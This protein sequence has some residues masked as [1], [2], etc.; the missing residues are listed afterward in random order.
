MPA[1][2]DTVRIT[3]GGKVGTTD[4]WSTTQAFQ[5]HGGVPS[6]ADMN[7]IANAAAL[8]WAAD[9]WDLATFGYKTYVP[10]TTDWS[11]CK[12]YYYPAGLAVATESGSKAIT[13]DPGTNVGFCPPQIALVVSLHTGFAG[14]RNRGRAYL[15]TPC[16]LTTNGH[17]SSA[18]T[19]HTATN[20]AKYLT[21][22]NAMTVG[23]LSFNACIGTFNAP[24]L[25]SVSVDDVVDTQR[26][27]RD[28]Q[29]ATVTSTATI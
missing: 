15:P 28:K 20:F 16:N 27:R 5:V 7:G 8:L 23:S 12:T 18:V 11:L 24:I 14:R 2:V 4:T 25:T 19:S 10:P 22:V 29:V 17:T 21:D 6:A 1:S 13:P 3:M 26:R 9:L